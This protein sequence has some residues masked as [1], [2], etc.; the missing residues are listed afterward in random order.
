MAAPVVTGVVAM[1][2]SQYGAKAS[3]NMKSRLMSTSRRFESFSGKVL[4]GGLINARNA[5]TGQT[6]MN[7]IWD[8]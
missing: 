4:S 3:K 8:K 6:S 2:I 7:F 1:I 5:L